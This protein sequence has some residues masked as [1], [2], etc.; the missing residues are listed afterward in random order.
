M[1]GEIR[2]ETP[3]SG[4]GGGGRGVDGR[5]VDGWGADRKEF[6]IKG[7]NGAKESRIPGLRPKRSPQKELIVSR[8]GFLYMVGFL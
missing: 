6:E 5:G 7:L 4:R 8:Y 3:P 2:L 1:T